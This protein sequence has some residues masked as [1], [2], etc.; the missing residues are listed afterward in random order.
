MEDNPAN[1][2]P[3]QQG[4]DGPPQFHVLQ[5]Q[6]I[7]EWLRF[8]GLRSPDDEPPEPAAYGSFMSALNRTEAKAKH[9]AE[10]RYQEEI[11][12]AIFKEALEVEEEQQ[13]HC[14]RLLQS[15]EDEM[16]EILTPVKRFR[17]PLSKLAA[18]CDTIF[19]MASSRRYIQSLENV[20]KRETAQDD[21]EEKMSLDGSSSCNDYAM[22]TLTL[23]DYPASSV[24]EFLDVALYKKPISQIG[25][26]MVV[27]CCQIGHYLQCARILHGTVNILMNHVDSENCLSLCQMAD[28][29]DLPDLFE[30]SLFHMLKSFD[31]LE[32]SD[33]YED[34]SPELKGRISEIR[35]VFTTKI[36]ASPDNSNMNNSSSGPVIGKPLYFT[37][38]Q[39]YIAI[40]AE[41]VQYY[42]E[43]L[44]EA[45][46]QNASKSG[47]A[48][49]YAQ[50]KIEKQELRVLTL[51]AML[52]EQKR[53]FGNN[54]GSNKRPRV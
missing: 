26:E 42:K 39:E 7:D 27:D 13:Q 9:E 50:S 43:R 49:A 22:V 29:L 47:E 48:Y 4:G 52:Q 51:E 40:F 18:E 8:N 17:V 15:W 20:R 31:H 23:D 5:I 28:R 6:D 35:Q 1:N 34:F 54:N 24:Q 44:A 10:E 37:S 41:N 25:D 36:A 11:H 19:T 2:E 3:Q 45:K 12:K 21:E 46:E 33:A 38:L 32:N 14:Q 16:M 53:M 30:R